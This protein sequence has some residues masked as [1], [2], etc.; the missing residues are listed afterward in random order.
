MKF[1]MEEYTK[2]KIFK[3]I[4]LISINM[5]ESFINFYINSNIF[6]KILFRLKI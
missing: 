2:I 6:L 5:I 1:F 3:T 4:L